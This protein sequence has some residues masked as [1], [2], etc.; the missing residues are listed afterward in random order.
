V[1]ISR[2]YLDDQAAAQLHL[3][4]GMALAIE[5]GTNENFFGFNPRISTFIGLAGLRQLF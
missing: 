5:L 2:H 1:G 4:R 3:E